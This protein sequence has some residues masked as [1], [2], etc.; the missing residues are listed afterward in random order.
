M[1]VNGTSFQQPSINFGLLAYELKLCADDSGCGGSKL[2]STLVD[3]GICSPF[4]PSFQPDAFMQ[5]AGVFSFLVMIFA[6]SSFFSFALS[7]FFFFLLA[8]HLKL[9]RFQVLHLNF[10]I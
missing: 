7:S 10:L 5:A 6:G 9:L 3:T 2:N 1:A 8:H 4:P